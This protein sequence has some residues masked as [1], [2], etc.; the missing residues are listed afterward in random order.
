MHAMY[1]YNSRE[2]S[3]EE[4]S[5]PCQAHVTKLSYSTVNAAG[6]A[7]AS[8]FTAIL[9]PTGALRGRAQTEIGNTDPTQNVKNDSLPTVTR[10]TPWRAH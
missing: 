2:L 5:Y 6:T 3:G 10:N 1:M 7:S 4:V 9:A 8:T